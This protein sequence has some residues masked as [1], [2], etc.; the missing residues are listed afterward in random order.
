MANFTRMLR[1]Q[2]NHVAY[3]VSQCRERRI[4][5]VQAEQ[6]AEDEW[7]DTN[8]E[9]AK[10]IRDSVSECTPEYYNQEGEVNDQALR[11]SSYG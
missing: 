10:M 6:T 1:H 2:A 8:M 3:V 11:N 5:S 7:N 4:K 9:S